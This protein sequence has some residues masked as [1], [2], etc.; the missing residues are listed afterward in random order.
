MPLN[1]KGFLFQL[2]GHEYLIN[3]CLT[4]QSAYDILAC[5]TEDMRLSPIW[6]CVVFFD[7]NTTSVNISD[8]EFKKLEAGTAF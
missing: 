4:P 7:K 1:C 5:V 3:Y 6:L 2:F 8:N